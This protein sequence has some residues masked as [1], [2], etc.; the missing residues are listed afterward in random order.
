MTDFYPILQALVNAT[1]D[2]VTAISKFDIMAVDT[3]K[4]ALAGQ[5]TADIGRLAA[6]FIRAAVRIIQGVRG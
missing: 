6:V 5:F 2:L 1:G 3:Q 4:L